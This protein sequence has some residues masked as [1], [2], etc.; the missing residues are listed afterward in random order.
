MKI[1]DDIQKLLPFGYLFLVIMGILKES[2]FYYQIGINILKYSTI[3]DIL[4]SPIAEFTSHPIIL[5]SILSLFVFHSYLPKILTKHSQ[6]KFVQ[7]A[8]ELKPTEAMSQ[9]EIKTYFKD[10]S[11]KSLAIVLSSFFLSYGI[12]GGY[13]LS[14]D[15]KNNKLKFQ[16]TLNFNSGE[17]QQVSLINN[18]SL[19]YFYITKGSKTIK[20]ASVQAVKNIEFT[21]NTMIP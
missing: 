16:H 7:K 11:I 2:F 10:V 17:S 15:I 20:I 13:F 8:F 18:N 4:I 6:K 5:I 19:Y 3:M 1:S 21:K 14:R 9:T 12:A